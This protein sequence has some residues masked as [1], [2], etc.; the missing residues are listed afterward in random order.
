MYVIRTLDLLHYI[1]FNNSDHSIID[2]ITEQ[3]LS[4]IFERLH[5]IKL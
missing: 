5:N 2:G 4:L 3:G 1:K